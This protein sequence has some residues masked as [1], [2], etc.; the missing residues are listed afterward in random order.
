VEHPSAGWRFYWYKAAPDMFRRYAAGRRRRHSYF[1]TYEPL[2]G[3]MRVP[4]SSMDKQK[5][6][7][8][9]VELEEE[10]QCIT[11]ITVKRSLCGL[12]VSFF[13]FVSV[14]IL[15]FSSYRS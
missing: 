15:S 11:L 14:C 3:S 10:T 13:L 12:E 7:G 8:T 9:D 4:T 1:Y 5:R 6:Q 2:P